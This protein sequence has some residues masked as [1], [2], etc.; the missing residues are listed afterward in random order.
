[1]L[2]KWFV[3]LMCF[4]PERFYQKELFIVIPKRSTNILILSKFVCFNQ[5]VELMFLRYVLSEV[6]LGQV[7][8]GEDVK[9]DI[10]KSSN[11]N[12]LFGTLLQQDILNFQL[13]SIP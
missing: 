1:M 3:Y 6:R 9:L 11:I 7:R 10:T 4:H 8:R 12:D 2:A 5:S 13:P